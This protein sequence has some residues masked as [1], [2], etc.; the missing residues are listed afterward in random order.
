MPLVIV[1]KDPSK[2]SDKCK[3]I[4][5]LRINLPH[6]VSDALTVPNTEA[7][8]HHSDVKVHFSDFGPI[9]VFMK[10]LEIIVLA[11]DHPKRAVDL[12][13]RQ[14]EIFTRIR[15]VI[16]DHIGF[17]LWVRLAKAEYSDV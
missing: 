11:N 17:S 15:S 13:E 2:L 6:F 8:L 10:P 9:D 14:Q 16:P 7:Q 4:R 3:I 5:R 12:E 1:K